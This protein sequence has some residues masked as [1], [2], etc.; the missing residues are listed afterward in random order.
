MLSLILSWLIVLSKDGRT[1]VVLKVNRVGYRVMLY[2]PNASNARPIAQT[3]NIILDCVSDRVYE[4]CYSVLLNLHF[5]L[6]SSN[7]YFLSPSYL[8]AVG[9]ERH[10]RQCRNGSEVVKGNA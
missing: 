5:M 9:E 6:P 2:P 7:T 3:F 1:P 10:K 4:M 8:N